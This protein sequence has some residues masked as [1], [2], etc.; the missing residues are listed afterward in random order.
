MIRVFPVSLNVPAELLCFFRTV[1]DE[2]VPAFQA[3]FRG[4]IFLCI[5][6]YKVL[7]CYGLK[8]SHE[9]V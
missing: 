2:L 9:G 4:Q 3:L 5:L 7:Y 6:A 1:S 8:F